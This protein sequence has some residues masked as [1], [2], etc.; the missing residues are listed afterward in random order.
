MGF[1]REGTPRN[2]R[3]ARSGKAEHFRGRAPVPRRLRNWIQYCYQQLQRSRVPMEGVRAVS[4]S[5]PTDSSRTKSRTG[6]TSAWRSKEPARGGYKRS[7]RHTT[8]KVV[9]CAFRDLM[10]HGILQFTLR[11][12]FRCALH[13]CGCQG[14]RGLQLFGVD[15]FNGHAR[16]RRHSPLHHRWRVC[17]PQRSRA[18]DIKFQSGSIQQK[19]LKL[20][21][22][23]QEVGF[24]YQQFA[25]CMR[26]FLLPLTATGSNTSFVF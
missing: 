20:S 18:I 22:R 21:K 13:H 4:A 10:I 15:I 1:S 8:R 26:R 23:N 24:K 19:S 14:I 12:A 16:A 11:I 17:E 25:G 3:G 7:D 6:R 9:P 2:V 5:H